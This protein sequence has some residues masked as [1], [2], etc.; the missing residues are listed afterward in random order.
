M[1]NITRGLE[2]VGHK[3]FVDSLFSSS[4]LFDLHATTIKSCSSVHPKCKGIPCKFGSKTV[5]VIRV[6]N[7]P[8]SGEI[9][10]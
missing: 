10:L 8:E 9:R 5:Q 6:T 4:A 2:E 7:K 3:L 1:S